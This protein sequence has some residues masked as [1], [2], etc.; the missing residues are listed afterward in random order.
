MTERN[1]YVD[2]LK[3]EFDAY[4]EKVT[5][6]FD[7]YEAGLVPPPEPVPRP[8]VP[9][10]FVA[11][12]VGT[13]VV[14]GWDF[15]LPL[16]T[17]LVQIHRRPD[18]REGDG[19]WT[20]IT[21]EAVEGYVDEYL[22]AFPQANPDA[23]WEYRIRG[24]SYKLDGTPIASV[25]SDT[26]TVEDV[27]RTPPVV[28]PEPE[29]EPS[30]FRALDRIGK[31]SAENKLWR[32]PAMRAG[33][34][35]RV[36]QGNIGDVRR[37]DWTEGDLL[38]EDIAA[39]CQSQWASNMHVDTAPRPGTYTW[40]NIEC[41]NSDG[42]VGQTKNLWGAR[43]H[44]VPER[45]IEDCDY[46]WMKEHGMY[47]SPQEGS[48]VKR[49]TFVNVGAQGLQY[50]HRPAAKPDKPSS[51]PNNHSYTKKPT[52][53]VDDCHMIDCGKFAGRGSFSLT[54]F[55][56]GSVNYPGTIKVSNSSFVANWDEPNPDYFGDYHATGAF[57]CTHGGWSDSNVWTG[58]CQYELV[59]LKNNLYDYTT[60]DRNIVAIRSADNIVIEDCAF[61]IRENHRNKAAVSI[62]SYVDDPTIKSNTITLRNVH[63]PGEV[64]KV[65]GAGSTSLHCPGEEVIIDARTGV[66]ISR[67]SL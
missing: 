16:E 9:V 66:E 15:P 56:C 12:V 28:D 63:A 17:P 30:E 13:T 18:F 2:A 52:Y 42:D 33:R 38:T 20:S 34:T 49:S 54:Y 22:P 51:Y 35:G 65:T 41:T 1:E 11:E 25:W 45:V 40:K 5:D 29:P 57:V 37:G 60:P 39:T 23:K 67:S 46:S 6:I 21:K 53:I 10:N 27:D 64:V 59:E 14:L 44:Y 26:I 4:S 19:G 31:T 8:V 62:D 36:A 61:I 55:T 50:A 43:E 3:S 47:I 58:G 7:A 32:A 48:T 24:F